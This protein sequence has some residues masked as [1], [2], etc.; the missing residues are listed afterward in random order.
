MG[1]S[2]VLGIAGRHDVAGKAMVVDMLPFLG[3]LFGPPGTTA[4]SVRP[5]A[6]AFVAASLAASAEARQRTVA[7][8]IA[9]MVKEG[10]LR[11]Q[12]LADALASDRQVTASAYRELIVTD[13]RPQLPNISLPVTVL[14]VQTPNV[15]LTAEQF[16]ALYQASYASLR[17]AKLKRID[18]SL[19]FIMH[20]QPQRFAEEVSAFLHP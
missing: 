18:D 6:D 11:D 15:P 10:S 12:A 19:H 4:E 5:T 3:I 9:T 14:Y 13:L 16:D 1:G 7:A 2:V 17:T 20:D 8:N